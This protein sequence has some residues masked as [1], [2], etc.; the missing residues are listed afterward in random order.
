M[1]LILNLQWYDQFISYPF[2]NSKSRWI[3]WT[4][5]F[6]GISL[7]FCL[8]EER[9]LARF[10]VEKRL[11]ILESEDLRR[12]LQQFFFLQVLQPYYSTGNSFPEGSGAS[13]QHGS[14]ELNDFAG[15]NMIP[16]PDYPDLWLLRYGI[17]CSIVIHGRCCEDTDREFSL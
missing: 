5:I 15:S 9:K 8:S 2:T 10:L 12:C 13:P 11:E 6:C 17:L 14:S 16:S 3:Y 7:C 1:N 4:A